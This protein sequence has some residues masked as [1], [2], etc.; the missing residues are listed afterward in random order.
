LETTPLEDSSQ[1]FR[2][3]ARESGEGPVRSQLFFKKKIPGKRPGKGRLDVNHAR[4]EQ[5]TTRDREVRRKDNST[6][7]KKGGH[8][9]QYRMKDQFGR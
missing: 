6:P 9:C 7:V 4:S 2:T 5:Q 8:T 1:H 3:W